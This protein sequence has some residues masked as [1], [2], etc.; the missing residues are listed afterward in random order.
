MRRLIGTL[1]FTVIALVTVPALGREFQWW[2]AD[3]SGLFGTSRYALSTNTG[4]Y[5]ADL[6]T[7]PSRGTN[8]PLSWRIFWVSGD[9]REDDYL[10]SAF[11]LRNIFPT[12]QDNNA[13][14]AA[15]IV[16]KRLL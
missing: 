10:N 1:L 7:E 8:D 9:I 3:G 5:P 16:R 14:F 2:R 13:N 4:F 15:G 6:L 12:A 11:N